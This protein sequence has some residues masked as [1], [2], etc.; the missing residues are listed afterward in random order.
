MGKTVEIT[1]E[2]RRRDEAGDDV[3][4]HSRDPMIGRMLLHH[5][6]IEEIGQGGMSVV[7]RGHDEKLNRD[8]AIKVLHPFLTQK[9]ECRARLQREAQAVARL[10]HPNIV[11][12]FGNS[13][14]T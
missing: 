9:P 8:V 4:F 2:D 3:P 5:K 11:K 6:V 14:D 12:I 10:D 1:R 13:G 7:Y